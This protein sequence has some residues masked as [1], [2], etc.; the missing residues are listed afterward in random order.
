M[1]ALENTKPS[2]VLINKYDVY[3]IKNNDCNAIV[4]ACLA[5]YYGQQIR[6]VGSK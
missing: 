5:S 6:L 3:G 2:D 1:P 4:I